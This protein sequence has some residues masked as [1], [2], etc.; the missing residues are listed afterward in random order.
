MPSALSSADPRSRCRCTSHRW[1]SLL[2]SL[3]AV[4]TVLTVLYLWR[5]LP[6]RIS[7]SVFLLAKIREGSMK[8]HMLSIHPVL[9]RYLFVLLGS[10]NQ[11]QGSTGKNAKERVLV[12]RA[13]RS[14]LPFPVPGESSPG[15]QPR[16][17][18]EHVNVDIL[19][20]FISR[21]TAFWSCQSTISFRLCPCKADS[22]AHLLKIA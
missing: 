6:Y 20:Y 13:A 18:H 5:W 14:D 11:G 10:C 8:T 3:F 12:L 9:F 1:L 2:L 21:Q 15:H 16:H 19:S 22:E 4:L 7:T 17:I